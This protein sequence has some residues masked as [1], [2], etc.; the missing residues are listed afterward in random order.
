MEQ[1]KSTEL[2][3]EGQAEKDD[4]IIKGVFK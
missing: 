1:G 4:R 2:T 3:P